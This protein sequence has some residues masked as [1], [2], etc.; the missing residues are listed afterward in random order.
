MMDAEQ[1]TEVAHL[2]SMLN[3]LVTDKPEIESVPVIVIA[4]VEPTRVVSDELIVI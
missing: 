4:I 3:A 1:S 2:K